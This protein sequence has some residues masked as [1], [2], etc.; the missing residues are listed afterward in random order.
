MLTVPLELVETLND[1]VTVALSLEDE[2]IV[3]LELGEG[4]TLIDVVSG[5]APFDEL[6]LAPLFVYED[7]RKSHSNV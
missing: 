2:L 5:H 1:S 3:S 7:G 4:D 6:Q